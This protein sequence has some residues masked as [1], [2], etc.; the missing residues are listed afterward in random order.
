M[1]PL[2]MTVLLV[3]VSGKDLLER[4]MAGRPGFAEYVKATSGF[5]PWWPR[6]DST[7]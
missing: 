7:S 2:V 3:K 5:V 6:D 1:G 4:G